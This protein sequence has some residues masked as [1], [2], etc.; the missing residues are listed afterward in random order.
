MNEILQY[1]GIGS[2]GQEQKQR[3]L[4]DK[5]RRWN[6]K[7]D[8]PLEQLNILMS[9]LGMSPYGRTETTNKTSESK[10]GGGG[11][12]MFGGMLQMIPGL[13]SLASDRTLKTDIE[14]LGTDD[15]TDLPLYAYR[16]KKDPKTYPKTV[17]PMAQ[18][19]EKKY[20]AL[21]RTVAGKKV[22]DLSALAA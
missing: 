1:L 8:Y 3:E 21:V 22:I 9:A 20:P 15:A 16:Y 18:D 2:M 14:R 5:Y 12:G 4:D 6:E 11:A 17:G 13:M 10:V 7:K 19:V